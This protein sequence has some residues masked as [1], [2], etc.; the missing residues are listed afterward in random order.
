MYDACNELLTVKHILI[1]CGIYHT[2]EINIIR[3]DHPGIDHSGICL[4]ATKII[5]FLKDIDLY[6]KL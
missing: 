5:Q 3:K 1:E 6:D 2:Q 4:R